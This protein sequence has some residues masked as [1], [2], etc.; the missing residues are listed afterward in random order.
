MFD[1]ITSAEPQ[2]FGYQF[3]KI[4]NAIG[5]EN[6][7]SSSVYA[8]TDLGL[9]TLKCCFEQ[10]RDELEVVG[11]LGSWEY[12]LATYSRAIERLQDYFGRNQAGLNEHDAWVYYSH[13]ENNYERFCEIAAEIEAE[14]R[15]G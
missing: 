9:K 15:K 2:K 7:T 5:P 14:L 11:H 13:L 12:E 10:F 3:E 6:Q 1:S 8:A 4:R